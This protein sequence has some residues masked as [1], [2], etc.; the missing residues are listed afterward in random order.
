MRFAN[1]YQYFIKD[2]SQIIDTFILIVK[3][4]KAKSLAKD[5]T[6]I[7]QPNVINRVGGN[8]KVDGVNFTSILK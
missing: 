6:A 1:F 7:A 5:L 4:V 3:I 8:I 2:F